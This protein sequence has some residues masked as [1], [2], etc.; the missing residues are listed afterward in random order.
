[1]CSPYPYSRK[2]GSLH[3]SLFTTF[4][5]IIDAISATLLSLLWQRQRRD[6]IICPAH[7]LINYIH[8]IFC[9]H[10]ILTVCIVVHFGYHRCDIIFDRHVPTHRIFI[11]LLSLSIGFFFRFGFVFVCC[12]LLSSSEYILSLISLEKEKQYSVAFNRASRRCITSLFL[13]SRKFFCSIGIVAEI[14][15]RIVSVFFFF[16]KTFDLTYTEEMC[17]ARNRR[18]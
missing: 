6:S 14:G 7:Q 10:Y 9:T 8:I 5:P 16:R 17:P 13:T 11:W 15:A 2:T 1:M 3:L 4:Q 12:N 18:D